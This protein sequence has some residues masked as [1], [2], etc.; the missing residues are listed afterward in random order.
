[1]NDQLLNQSLI[2]ATRKNV[3]DAIDACFMDS[4]E[5]AFDSAVQYKKEFGIDLASNQLDT[6]EAVADPTIRSL[7]T[8]Q[9][10]SGGKTFSVIAGL[11]KA[12]A[13]G[14][15]QVPHLK[16]GLTAPTDNQANR[17]ITTL[18]TEVLSSSEYARS[19]IDMKSTTNT[20]VVFKSG[21]LWEAFSGNLLSNNEGR[22]YDWIWNDEAQ[23]TSGFSMTN[24][25]LPMIGHSLSPKI[26]KTGVPRGRDH[27][28]KSCHSPDYCVLVYDWLNCPRLFNAGYFELNGIKYPKSIHSRLSISVCQRLFPNNP[29]YWSNGEIEWDDFATQYGMQ[30]LLDTDVFLSETDQ[31][32][33]LGDFE[34]DG[35]QTEEYFFGLDIAGGEQIKDGGCYTALSI[36]RIRNGVKEKV[37]TLALQG[38]SV[39]QIEDLL[40]WV[41]P[42]YGKYRCKWGLCDYGFNASVV[43]T[44]VTSGV[45]TEGV[46]FG[47]R[48]PQTGKNMKNAMYESF[49][50]EL[51]SGRFKYPSRRTIDKHKIMKQHFNEW[52]SLER[53][54]GKGINDMIDPPSGTR[55]DG[56]CADILLNRAMLNQP[57][58]M[59]T[60]KSLNIPSILMGTPIVGDKRGLKIRDH[61]EFNPFGGNIGK[62]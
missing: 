8:V 29:E 19:L 50:F 54:R 33:L 34:F 30:W 17:I 61:N 27:F 22:H 21:G 6:A 43:D 38:N 32:S 28:F 9:A 23:K 24:I 41:H 14:I 57:T 44:L 53:H 60:K 3:I 4:I 16:V 42:V 59:N 48:D 55:S 37:D 12:T 18:K 11:I 40:S 7:A 35:P 26:I 15:P 25:L 5:S 39:D 46:L 13:Y 47:S 45:K 2:K 51:R 10:R 31:A 36:G 49:L 20:R 52:C 58:Q 1:M 62:I 56:P